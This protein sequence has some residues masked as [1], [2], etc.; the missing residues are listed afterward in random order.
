MGK[1]GIA[2]ASIVHDDAFAAAQ[3]VAG[4]LLD[5][6]GGA[7]DLVLVFSSAELSAERVA[8]GLRGRLP[9]ATRVVGCSSY[10]EINREEALTR[11]VTALGL[12]L[13]RIEQ[14]SFAIAPGGGTSFEAGRRAGLELR[15]FKPDLVIALPDVLQLNATQLLLGLQDALGKGVPVIGGAPADRGGFQRTYQIRDGEV[16]SGGAVGVALKGPI[17]LVTGARSGY[18]PIGLPH[19][20]TRVE[21]GNVIREIDGRPALR[22]YKGLLGPLAAGMP[23]I[24]IEFPIGVVGGV[25]GTQRQPDDG[26]LLVRAI[27]RVDEEHEALVLGGDIPEG[28]QVQVTRAT[29]D[30]I[31]RGAEEA[32]ARALEAMPEPD[33]ALIFSCM[34]RKN[35]LGP[36]YKDE[37]AAAFSRL[38]PGLPKMGFYTFG[39][40]SPVQGVTMHHES[41]FTL[42]LLQLG[43]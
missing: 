28:A 23:A 43:A 40:L 20:C 32:T 21:G 22:L 35:V 3:E 12:R 26:L 33:L 4:E 6:L 36:R 7:P 14:R 11:S 24:S 37:C 17:R 30:D 8:G 2:V 16:L 34:S 19:T 10:A 5:E 18:Q 9:G 39:E 38:P 31:I 25:R 1:S 15:D 42:G 41:T 29:R 13:G 27:F